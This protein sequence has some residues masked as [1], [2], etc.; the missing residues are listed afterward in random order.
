MEKVVCGSSAKELVQQLG[1]RLGVGKSKFYELKKQLKL[2]FHKDDDGVWIDAD[3][4]AE[5][6]NVVQGQ[7]HIVVAESLEM[8]THAEEIQ[9]ETVSVE[10]GSYQE[11]VRSAQ[12][13]A[14]G[15]AIARYQLASQM[16]EENLPV[17]L[18]EKIEAARQRTIPKSKSPEAIAKDIVQRARQTMM[19]A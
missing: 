18:Q 16:D 8:E 10:D 12:E 15:M 14:A 2:E 19:A 6:E 5:L 3:Q 4:L 11:L 7:A 1:D 13:L 9:A 17:D